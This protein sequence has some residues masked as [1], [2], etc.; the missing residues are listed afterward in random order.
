MNS[1]YL[2]LEV[3]ENRGIG[4]CLSVATL[5]VRELGLGLG[6]DNPTNIAYVLSW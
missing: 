5:R 6:V 3:S 2:V 4:S 1:W